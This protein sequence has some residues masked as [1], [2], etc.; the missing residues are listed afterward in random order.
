MSNTQSN[1]PYSNIQFTDFE[2]SIIE[3]V[4][5]SKNEPRGVLFAGVHPENSQMVVVGFSLCH[6]QKDRFD[7]IKSKSGG[8][9]TVEG[10]GK[11]IAARRAVKWAGSHAVTL[12]PRSDTDAHYGVVHVPPSIGV[13]L[14]L[15]LDRTQRYFKDKEMPMWANGV[16]E[17]YPSSLEAGDSNE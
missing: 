4:R 2:S 5:G 1:N 7:K 8:V 3:Y 15:F 14:S 6:K 10:L 9:S 11:N 16:Y 13:D 12:T 17:F